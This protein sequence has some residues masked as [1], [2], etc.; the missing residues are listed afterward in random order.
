MLLSKSLI[1]FI[2]SII[3]GVQKYPVWKTRSG[4]PGIR[5]LKPGKLPGLPN[6]DNSGRVPGFKIGY[7]GWIQIANFGKPGT[8]YPICNFFKKKFILKK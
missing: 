4:K 1:Q 3:R 8:R 7:S 2:I 6:S 5:F